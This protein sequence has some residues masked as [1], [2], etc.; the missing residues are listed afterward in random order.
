MPTP[1]ESAQLNLQLFD[2]R[3]EPVLR[4]AR[5]WFLADFNPE[6]MAD[7]MAAVTGERNA[8]FRMVLGYWDMA[9]SLVSSGAIDADS[10]LAAHTEIIGT[11]CKIYPFVAEM[12][13]AVGE[14]GFLKHM[15]AVVIAAPD[16]EATLKRRRERLLA[17]AR[18]H[19]TG[20]SGGR[21]EGA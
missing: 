9:A 16:A 1:F 12:R 15:E 3:R 19:K 7:L 11:F 2:L 20:Q 14:P 21:A 13:S 6:T 18:A 5:A 8:S 4:E 17:V 10:F